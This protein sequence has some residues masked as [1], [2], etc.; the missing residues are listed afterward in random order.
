MSYKSFNTK[1]IDHTRQP[2][3]FGEN[4]N[5]SRYDIVKYPFFDKL[6][7]KQLSH[8]WR[9][10]EIN[11]S[12]DKGDYD[13]LSE[14]EKHIF[15][16]NLK[17]QTMLDSI[18]GRGPNVGLLPFVSLP[19]LET[20]IENWGANETIH[21]RSYTYI[22]KNIFVE[23]DKEFDSIMEND[24]IVGCAKQLSKYYDDVIN[25]GNF[26]NIFGEGLFEVKDK[27]SNKM[28][29]MDISLKE[30]KRKFALMIASINILEGVRFYVSFACSWAFAE[31]ELMEGNAKIIKLICRDENLH[32]ASTQQM[33][34]NF[35]DNPDEGMQDAWESVKDEVAEMFDEAV[36]NEKQWAK[37]LFKKDSMIGLNEKILS[38]FVEWVANKRLDA[39]GL[40][41][42]YENDENPLPWII[43]WISEKGTVNNAQVAPQE[44]EISSYLI[45]SVQQDVSK[46]S[47][48]DFDLYN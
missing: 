28:I 24:E 17:R 25:Y 35:R 10:E 41:K 27:T 20:W 21:A 6:I 44:T 7:D 13:K 8:F 36:N 19:E 40:E 32:L 16:S 43:P 39:L 46:E 4:V 48:N 11:I 23:P 33:I 22:L 29:K 5:L 26:Y 14:A 38:N 37:Y 45:G 34:R 9:P 31:R 42:R 1:K 12:K 47:F 15:T 30:L 3:F 2:M 18:Q